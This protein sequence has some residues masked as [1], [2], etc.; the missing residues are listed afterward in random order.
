MDVV[1]VGAGRVGTALAVLLRRAGHRIVAVAGRGAPGARPAKDLPGVP[2]VAPGEAARLG[3]LVLLTVPDD[4]IGEVAGSRAASGAFRAGAWVAH[5]SGATRL[6]E[7]AP[8]RARGARPLVIHPLQTFP[9]VEGAIGRIP[10]SAIAVTADD[11]EGFALAERLARDLGGRPFRLSDEHR[12][13]Y[14]AA[15]VFASNY[16]VAALGQAEELMR[17]SGVPEPVAALAP[18]VRATVDNVERLGPGHALTGPAVRGDAGTVARNLAALAGSAPQAV[19]PYVELAH[20]ALALGTRSG[21]L[22]DEARA[23][24]EEVLDR[25]R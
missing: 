1:V 24:V 6:E 13:L 5:V 2:V 23:R 12:A 3:D 18:L 19:A 9:D 10:G 21:R 7:L 25:W 11:E 16:V 14:H 22:S 4:A 8:V 20:L 15:A 17:L